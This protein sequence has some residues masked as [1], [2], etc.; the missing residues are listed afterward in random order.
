MTVFNLV[1]EKHLGFRES[2]VGSRESGVGSQE[3]GV[4][5]VVKNPVYLISLII[6]SFNKNCYLKVVGKKPIWRQLVKQI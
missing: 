2:G 4:G 1:K 3:S 6:A 5:I